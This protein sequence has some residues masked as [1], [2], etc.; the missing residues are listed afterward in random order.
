MGYLASQFAANGSIQLRFM[1]QTD[2]L[3]LCFLKTRLLGFNRIRPDQDKKQA[4]VRK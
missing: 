3:S 1:N 2:H 4:I